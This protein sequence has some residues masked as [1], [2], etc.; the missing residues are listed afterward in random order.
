MLKLI[1][2]I[3]VNGNDYHYYF[4]SISNL[5]DMSTVKILK[6]AEKADFFP[7]LFKTGF[8][9]NSIELILPSMEEE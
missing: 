8:V 3:K 6:S 4:V 1:I 7:A 5:F 9:I 2:P